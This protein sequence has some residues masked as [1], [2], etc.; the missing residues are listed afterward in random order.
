F[1]DRTDWWNYI[2]SIPPPRIVVL[3]DLDPHPYLGALVGEV[4][5]SILSALGCVALVTNGAVRRP[6]ASKAI[7]FQLFSSGTSVSHA[8]AHVFDFGSTV[9][10]GRMEV[11]SGDLLHGD[12]CGIQTVP[13][14]IVDKL[15]KAAK[16][17]AEQKQRVIQL[18]R[19]K[20]F[21]LEKLRA[22]VKGS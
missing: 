16:R 3:Q 11:R 7:G 15:D 5:A 19:S 18:C 21:S 6:T 10:V 13:L 8:Y 2:V 12:G 22:V 9:N 14:N 17:V 20:D 1:T 4:H